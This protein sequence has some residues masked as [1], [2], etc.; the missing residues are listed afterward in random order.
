MIAGV[1][2]EDSNDRESALVLLDEETE[3]INFET[4]QE[5]VEKLMENDV[6]VLAVNAPFTKEADEEK[7]IE[8]GYSFL[9]SDHHGDLMKRGEAL[10]KLVKTSMGVDRPE[11]IRF[12]PHLTREELAVDSEEDLES[13][14]VSVPD[15]ESAKQFDAMLGAVTARFYELNQCVDGGVIVPQPRMES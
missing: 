1:M 6:E 12:S 14:G 15:L 8:E 3:V 5:L 11:I 4:N 10:S 13:Y 2:L 7:I 9:P